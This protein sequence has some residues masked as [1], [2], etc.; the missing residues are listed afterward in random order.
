MRTALPIAAIF[1]ILMCMPLSVAHGLTEQD[2]IPRQMQAIETCKVRIAEDEKVLHEYEAE[3]RRI[4]EN[5]PA[6]VRRRTEIRIIKKHYN[7][8]IEVNKA[9]IVDYYKRIQ[10]IRKRMGD[11]Q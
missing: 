1:A 10:E 3:L 7:D 6:S 4:T 2:S 5:D 9:K 8:E 11:A